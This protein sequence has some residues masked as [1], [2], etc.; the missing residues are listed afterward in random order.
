MDALIDTWRWTLVPW[1]WAQNHE[2]M[3]YAVNEPCHSY[4]HIKTILQHTLEGCTPI[5]IALMG[6]AHNKECNMVA[7]THDCGGGAITHVEFVGLGK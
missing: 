2:Q 5:S 3:C 1:P 6:S 7:S 4:I